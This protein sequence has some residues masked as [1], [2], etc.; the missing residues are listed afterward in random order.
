MAVKVAAAVVV[1][2][3]FVWSSETGTFTLFC[4]AEQEVPS[5]IRCL[6]SIKESLEDP[7]SSLSHW[8]LNNNTEG[9]SAGLVAWSAG[10]KTRTK[11]ST[12]TSPAWG[13]RAIFLGYRGLP[14][15]CS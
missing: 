1:V 4:Y 9:L 15:L 6:K 7:L 14:Q 11:S 13:L 5:D 10:T 3:L 8:N 12:S 2:L